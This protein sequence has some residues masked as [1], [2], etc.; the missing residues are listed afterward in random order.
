ME[1]RYMVFE[2]GG[3]ELEWDQ[4]SVAMSLEKARDFLKLCKSQYPDRTFKILHE[5]QG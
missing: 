5:I 4:H 2:Y 3:I 1:E